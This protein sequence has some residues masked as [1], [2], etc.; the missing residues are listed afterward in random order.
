MAK[1]RWYLSTNI[2][3]TFGYCTQEAIYFNCNIVASPRACN[4][5]MVPEKCIYYSV[6]EIDKKFD[7]ED[8]TVPFEWTKRW[9][10]NA[11]LMIDI[12]K[13]NLDSA[14]ENYFNV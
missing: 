4:P 8:L 1:A 10:G 14:P 13:E 5:E 12:C 2:Q 7:T 11:Q 6:N 9:H 3:E